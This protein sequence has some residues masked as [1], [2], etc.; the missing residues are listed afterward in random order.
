MQEHSFQHILDVFMETRLEGEC[1]DIKKAEI[2]LVNKILD[3]T[4]SRDQNMEE[5]EKSV[6]CSS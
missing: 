2:L 6:Y 4:G 3:V 5:E 1:T